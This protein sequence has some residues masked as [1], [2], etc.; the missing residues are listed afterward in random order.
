MFEEADLPVLTASEVAEEL[1]CSRPSAY[2]KLERLVEQGTI[3]KRRSGQERR[4]ISGW[5][6]NRGNCGGQLRLP[7]A[8]RLV[9]NLSLSKS[10]VTVTC[11]IQSVLT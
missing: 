9:V 4:S 3:K 1:D 10:S 8:N 7:E 6:R 2:N 11:R 5:M